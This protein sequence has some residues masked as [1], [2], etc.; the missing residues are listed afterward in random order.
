METLVARGVLRPGEGGQK[1][2]FQLHPQAFHFAAGD[3]AKLE[4]L[5]SD[6]PYV[7]PSNLQLPIEVANLELRLPVLEQPG[8]LG[9]LVQAPAPKVLPPG[10]QAALGYVGETEPGGEE[11]GGGGQER[12]EKSGGGPGGGKSGPTTVTPGTAGLARGRITAMSKALSLRLRCAGQTQCSGTLSV[13]V[14]GRELAGGPYS[15][16]G[17]LTKRLRLPLDAP[18]RRF[19]ASHRGRRTGIPAH[20]SFNDSGRGATP[21]EL[22]RPIHLAHG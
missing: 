3:V 7:R 8:A 19:V 21:F 22:T 16:P 20:L 6:A 9:G 11:K 2:V 18:G 5:P 14:G 13:G 4:L 15:I 1:M 10:Y 12:E 17:G